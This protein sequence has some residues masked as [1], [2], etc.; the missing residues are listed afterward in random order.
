MFQE[1]CCMPRFIWPG[2]VL[3]LALIL[4]FGVQAETVEEM[5]DAT[6]V[7][8]AL[9][10]SIEGNDLKFVAE[11]LDKGVD[12]S[13]KSDKGLMPL[14]AACCEDA[15]AMVKLLLERG[16]D[17]E[18]RTAD[19]FTPLLLAVLNKRPEA[20]QI[21]LAA[22]AI[23]DATCSDDGL[24]AL[25]AAAQEGHVEMANILIAHGADVN[26]KCIEVMGA[27]PLFAAVDG[28]HRDVA[29]LLLQ[30][31]ADV[32]A[33]C[34]VKGF[35]ALQLASLSNYPRM[36]ELLLENGASVNVQ[37]STNGMT[38]FYIAQ[39]AGYKETA[40]LLWEHDADTT[41]TDIFGQTPMQAAHL[42]QSAA[43]RRL[44]SASERLHHFDPRAVLLLAPYVKGHGDIPSYGTMGGLRV[45][46]AIGDGSLLATAWHCVDLLS[47]LSGTRLLVISPYYGD[48]FE[49]EVI[50]MSK[51]ADL[52]ILRAPW[53]SHP[54][55][56]LASERELAETSEIMIA[57]YQPLHHKGATREYDSVVSLE[58]MP[59]LRHDANR[60]KEAIAAGCAR[61]VGNGWSGSPIIL[62]ESGKLAGVFG[63]H[64]VYQSIDGSII[65]NNVMGCD[66]GAIRSLLKESGLEVGT[67][68]S[69][70]HNEAAVDAG[71]V[72]DTLYGFFELLPKPPGMKQDMLI[73]RQR[74]LL[75]LAEKLVRLRPDSPHVNVLLACTALE[76]HQRKPE[77]VQ[78]WE[79][80][81][82][83]FRKALQLSP[84]NADVH[85]AYGEALLYK[86]QYDK[87]LQELDTA[88]LIDQK[89]Y[90]ASDARKVV[91]AEMNKDKV[92]GACRQLVE[93]EPGN[94]EYW[95]KY[96]NALTRAEMHEEAVEAARKVVSL[97]PG[98]G[99]E[100]C[101]AD[102]LYNAGRPGE[103]DSCFE[104]ALEKYPNDQVIWYEY[105]RFL[106]D[107][108][109]GRQDDITRAI[110][111]GRELKHNPVSKDMWERM[112]QQ[113]N[114]HE[115]S[116]SENPQVR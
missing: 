60:D 113:S 96:V 74:K 61:F 15:S 47:Y 48:V 22:G 106:L 99:L 77:D 37:L 49:V 62:P 98:R 92:V 46:F 63:C 21:L 55:I 20:A 76:L 40:A 4:P 51:Q 52:A 108:H 23:V 85:A 82:A 69:L 97:A 34:G 68:T 115:R 31:G 114:A 111:H 94:V 32:N 35:A 36:T 66:V 59:L 100:G 65:M 86:K 14:H 18:A 12:I 102:A 13:T 29:D 103:A 87:A 58:R 57:G 27:T 53:S 110:T 11:L 56:S 39:V 33:D 8:K 64:E 17:I 7:R 75:T 70:T 30:N 84:Q 43:F 71:K 90:F 78:A 5:D 3:L 81:Q 107:K 91:I 95:L 83:G 6:I 19:D 89:M 26:R 25:H 38:A 105:A 79:L 50:A 80:A 24:S 44:T 67:S 112:Q 45:V 41:I 116:V 72:T 93:K 16:A 10:L 28:N 42:V 104:R 73:A 1:D 9:F 101:L 88:L 109:P 54:A 2:Y